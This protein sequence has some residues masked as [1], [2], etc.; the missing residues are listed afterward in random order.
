MT[1]CRNC[2]AEKASE[3]ICDELNFAEGLSPKARVWVQLH[4]A[5]DLLRV[6]TK[7]TMARKDPSLQRE[8]DAFVTGA[9]GTAMAAAK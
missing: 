3:C 5:L 8:L 9:L 4:S 1:I 6:V 2:F 7:K